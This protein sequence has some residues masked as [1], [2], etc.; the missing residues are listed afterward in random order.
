MEDKK[1]LRELQAMLGVQENFEGVQNDS[2]PQSDVLTAQEMGSPVSRM[3][4]NL[5]T[6]PPATFFI[7]RQTTYHLENLG[8]SAYI[9]NNMNRNSVG[10]SQAPPAQFG[11]EFQHPVG[12]VQP[13][14]NPQ[15]FFC[16]PSISLPPRLP[17]ISA[18]AGLSLSMQLP[19]PSKTNCPVS[20]SETSTFLNCLH[21]SLHSSTS[22]TATPHKITLGISYAYSST[23]STT[24]PT[25]LS[26]T[27]GFG[28][29]MTT[30]QSHDVIGDSKCKK[31][32]R[33][34]AAR[35][36]SYPVANRSAF[37]KHMPMR[38]NPAKTIQPMSAEGDRRYV[39]MLC[40][41]NFK[42]IYDLKR[43]EVGHNPERPYACDLC[44]K[45]FKRKDALKRHR[46]IHTK[47]SM[48]DEHLQGTVIGSLPI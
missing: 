23:S 35:S 34:F 44:G 37:I 20:P 5:V 19:R 31:Q 32:Q 10:E 43:H 1:V 40:N 33:E 2:R 38:A 7:E 24:I 14:P 13:H 29:S 12:Q 21:Q 8:S 25:T 42:R 48:N 30:Y 28:S 18:G 46:S 27:F 11:M 45:S 4:K 22:T 6:S 17:N 9:S 36:F 47:W 16:A 15:T 26:G 39:C 3:V 41:V